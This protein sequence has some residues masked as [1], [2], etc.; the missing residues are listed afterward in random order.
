LVALL[1]VFVGHVGQVVYVLVQ[2]A[3]K[4]GHVGRLEELEEEFLLLDGLLFLLV[5]GE[6]EERVDQ[7][8]VEVGHELGEEAVL[9]GDV[10]AIRR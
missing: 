3:H 1:L 6:V 8:P 7:V 10:G 2:L 5:A 4:V 9:F